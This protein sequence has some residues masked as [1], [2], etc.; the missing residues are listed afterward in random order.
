[1]NVARPPTAVT[2][3]A[4]D[5]YVSPPLPDSG[6]A[7]SP[8]TP[9]TIVRTATPLDSLG[10]RRSPAAVAEVAVSELALALDDVPPRSKGRHFPADP[11]RTEEIIASCAAPATVCTARGLAG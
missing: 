3:T 8:G 1:M 4:R 9:G 7:A 11:P 6:D 10:R 2:A 5:R